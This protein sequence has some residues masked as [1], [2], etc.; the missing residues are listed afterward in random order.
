M[1][2]HGCDNKEDAL[3]CLADTVEMSY[4]TSLYWDDI[5][6]NWAEVA[7]HFGATDKEVNEAYEKGRDKGQAQ[8]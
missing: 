2:T 8:L 3:W 1:E 4:T 6:A 5:I 7:K